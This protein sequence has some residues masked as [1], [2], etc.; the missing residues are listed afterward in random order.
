MKI[1]VFTGIALS[2][3][4][5]WLSFRGIEIR[6]VW[7]GIHKINGAFVISSLVVMILM[8]QS[9]GEL[10]SN[11]LISLSVTSQYSL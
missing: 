1:K 10:Y 9:A 3:L 6:E 4:L 5:V 8:Q 2:V 7:R 11:P